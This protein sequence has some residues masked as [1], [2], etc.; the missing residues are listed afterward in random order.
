MVILVIS[1]KNTSGILHLERN[2]KDSNL[3]I[4]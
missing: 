4:L 3:Y 1:R 2:V